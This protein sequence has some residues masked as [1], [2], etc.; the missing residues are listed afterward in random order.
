[1]TYLAIRHDASLNAAVAFAGPSDIEASIQQRPEMESR[2]Y[3]QLIPGEGEERRRQY[4][5]RSALYWPEALD[6]PLLLL[7]GDQDDRVY[8][9]HSQL[10][11]AALAQAGKPHRLVIYPG[12]NHTLSTHHEQFMTEAL[13]WFDRYRMPVTLK[14]RV[15]ENIQ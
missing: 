6:I 10:L 4:R 14:A 15:A 3:Q 7:H 13:G 1:M 12:G 11:A 2:V 8:V 5:A 9:S